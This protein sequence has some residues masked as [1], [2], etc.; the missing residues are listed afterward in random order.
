MSGGLPL[1]CPATF[2]QC[3]RSA[4]HAGFSVLDRMTGT[5]TA[6]TTETDARQIAERNYPGCTFALSTVATIHTRVV[7]PSGTPDAVVVAVLGLPSKMPETVA[8]SVLGDLL[9]RHVVVAY[10]VASVGSATCI[11]FSPEVW[12]GIKDHLPHDHRR[13]V[14]REPS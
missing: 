7:L 13:P 3:P 1:S 2:H 8:L 12:P 14:A 10:V 9:R 6:A 4:E 11:P 5:E